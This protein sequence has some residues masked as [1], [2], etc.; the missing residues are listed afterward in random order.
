M[1]PP[2]AI[3]KHLSTKYPK[4][5]VDLEWLQGCYDWIVGE[6]NWNPEDDLDKIIDEVESQ[7]LASDLRDSMVHGSGIPAR[8]ADNDTTKSTLSGPILV[9]IESITDIGV[10]AYNLN[11]TMSIREERRAAGESNEGEA[12]DEVEEEG[13]IPEFTRSM[14][15][16][17]ICDGSTTMR[18][19]EYRR[20]PQLKLGQTPLGFKLLIKNVEIR[21][22]IAFLEPDSVVLKGGE[23]YNLNQ[24]QSGQFA[25]SLR[26]RLGLPPD[27]EL[28]NEPPP[29]PMAADN[30]RSPLRDI[31]PPPAPTLSDHQRSHMDDEDQPRR[32]RVPNSSAGSVPSSSTT[33]VPT[34]TRTSRPPA[35]ASHKSAPLARQAPIDIESESDDEDENDAEWSSSSRNRPI[36]P[37]PARGRLSEGSPSVAVSNGKGKEKEKIKTIP[38]KPIVIDDD[39]D[40]FDDDFDPAFLAEIDEA[41]MK[42]MGDQFQNMGTPSKGSRTRHSTAV[43]E[44]QPR[45]QGALIAV[46]ETLGQPIVIDDDEEEEDK[47]N[48]P[49][50]QRSVRR[51]TS[52]QEQFPVSTAPPDDDIIDL[53][54]DD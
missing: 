41:E 29:S 1:P 24:R 45:S 18:A 13:P 37:L 4:P 20:I 46:S 16:F 9:Q 53:S 32:R 33:V 25:N 23:E 30:P 52:T 15:R 31:S 38:S 26:I 11:K 51:R 6:K 28:E 49:A 50:L 2:S 42:A 5:R 44:T 54:S 36:K 21:R 39:D 47:E 19:M 48:V 10:S 43:L 22:G 35:S 7:L 34:A 12:D 14:L 3:L 27:P 8:I 17:E 40:M